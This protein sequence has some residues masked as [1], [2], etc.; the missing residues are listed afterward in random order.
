MITTAAQKELANIAAA[1]GIPEADVLSLAKLVA[2]KI[3]THG[4]ADI[5]KQGGEEA[6]E[7]MQAAA[8]SVLRDGEAFMDQYQNDAEYRAGFLAD[9]I[10]HVNH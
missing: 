1:T 8:L 6:G 5:F 4:Y 7:I 2:L 9:L 3:E 10:D